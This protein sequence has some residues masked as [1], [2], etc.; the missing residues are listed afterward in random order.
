MTG[1]F[2]V[3]NDQFLALAFY[4]HLLAVLPTQVP[5]LID[6]QINIIAAV[7]L[8]NFADVFIDV[9]THKTFYPRI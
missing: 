2:P 8:L 9:S 3:L 4:D 6:R 1:L 5:Y 7:G